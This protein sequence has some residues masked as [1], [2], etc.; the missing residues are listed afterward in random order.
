MGVDF[1]F[2][3]IGI[4]IVDSESRLPSPRPTLSASGKLKSDAVALGQIAAK[5]YADII[6]LGL[7]LEPDGTE[8]R[9]AR[10]CRQLAGHLSELGKPVHLTDERLS[11]IEAQDWLFGEDLKASQRK[12]RLDSEAACI[13]LERYLNEPASD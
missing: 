1:G 8:G 9:L 2:K 3:R 6:V 11:S 10:I 13:I 4:A 5:E 7:P 12:K